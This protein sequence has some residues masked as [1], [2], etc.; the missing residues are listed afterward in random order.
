M[1][2]AFDHLL[3]DFPA[4]QAAFGY[5]S[6]IFRQHDAH[7]A[8]RSAAKP[9]LDFIFAVRDPLAWHEQVRPLS[10]TPM[11][12][13]LHTLSKMQLLMYTRASAEHKHEPRALLLPGVIWRGR[14]HRS[15]SQISAGASRDVH[16]AT[17]RLHRMVIHAQS[18]CEYCSTGV[19]ERIGAGV[20]FNTLVPWRQRVSRMLHLYVHCIGLE[21]CN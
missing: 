1:A 15:A 3:Q 5:G 20:H 11:H 8:A 7:S 12:E 14:S 6:G 19:A 18:A 16:A 2:V 21:H 17:P 13:G 10:S 9:M 4:V